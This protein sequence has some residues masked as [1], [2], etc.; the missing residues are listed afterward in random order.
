MRKTVVTKAQSEFTTRQGLTM[1]AI[2]LA[3]QIDPVTTQRVLRLGS[4]RMGC[5]VGGSPE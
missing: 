1:L 5:R 2:V 3:S 4:F